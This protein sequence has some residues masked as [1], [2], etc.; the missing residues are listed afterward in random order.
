MNGI[1][2]ANA[3]LNWRM[4][5]SDRANNYGSMAEGYH[6]AAIRLLDLLVRDNGGHDADVVIYPV[7]FSGHQCVELYL[8]AIAILSC[9]ANGN[10]PWMIEIKQVHNLDRLLNSVNSKLPDGEKIVKGKETQALFDFIDMCK[11]VG[12]DSQGEYFV[13]FARYPENLPKVG[14][15]P[16]TYPFVVK[17]DEFIF[18]LKELKELISETCNLLSGIY[19]QWFDRADFVRNNA[20][21]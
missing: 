21:E 7:L 3:F 19:A 15:I 18:N 11:Q 4:N 8:K 16:T 17:N 5:K 6:L 2:E 13:D 12:D 9:E 20:L 14:S 1:T 10:N